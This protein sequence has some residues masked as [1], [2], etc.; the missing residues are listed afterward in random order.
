MIIVNVCSE[1][2]TSSV[3]MN[4]HILSP[5]DSFILEY[6][7]KIS[8]D[9]KQLSETSRRKNGI[10]GS[11]REQRN[12]QVEPLPNILVT[13]CSNKENMAKLVSFH[14]SRSLDIY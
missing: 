1:V 12:V 13:D 11:S 6:R 9:Q 4:D 14:F 8:E 10:S 5:V 7:N 3:E 2:N